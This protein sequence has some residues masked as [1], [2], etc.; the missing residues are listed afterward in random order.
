MPYHMG[1]CETL[2]V[3]EEVGASR[4]RP[5]WIY[6]GQPSQASHLSIFFII[7]IFFVRPTIFQLFVRGI[8]SIRSSFN[9]EIDK[10]LTVYIMLYD[11]FK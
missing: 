1:L 4:R 11:N 8:N 5:C 9:S 10:R 7:Y 3:E 2:N 6:R